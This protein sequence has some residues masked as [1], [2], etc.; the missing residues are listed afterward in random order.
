LSQ[1]LFHPRPLRDFLKHELADLLSFD[2]AR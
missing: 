1:S 2:G